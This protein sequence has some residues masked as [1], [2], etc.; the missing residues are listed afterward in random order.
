MIF[1]ILRISFHSVSLQFQN[2][3]VELVKVNKRLLSNRLCVN[4]L[5]LD[6]L[7]YFLC[8][9]AHIS[10]YAPLM[11]FYPKSNLLNSLALLL[12]KLSLGMITLVVCV[13]KCQ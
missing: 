5:N 7:Y 6:K 12:M 4:L 11:L 8:K 13:L 3:N 9:T 10:S 2:L 1:V